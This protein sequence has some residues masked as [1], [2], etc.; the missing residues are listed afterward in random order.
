[1]TAIL[2]HGSLVVSGVDEGQGSPVV[3]LHSGGLSSRQWGRLTARLRD[4]YRVVAPDLLGYGTT[5][6]F[7]PAAPF[8]LTDEE[9]LV[10]ALLDSLPGRVALV[11]HSYG[12]L[13]ALMVARRRPEKVSALVVYEPVAFGVLHEPRDEAALNDL[14]RLDPDG[15]FLDDAAGGSE[16]KSSWNAALTSIERPSAR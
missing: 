3:L 12:G 6:G 2:Q 10:L 15:T 8:S 11:G 14:A 4:E 16:P 13:L 9:E 7:D 5:G 1:M